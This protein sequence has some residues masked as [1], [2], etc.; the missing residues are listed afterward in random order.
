[1]ALKHTANKTR[2]HK[3]RKEKYEWEVK[4]QSIKIQTAMPEFGR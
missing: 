4:K 1:M 3:S 2:S